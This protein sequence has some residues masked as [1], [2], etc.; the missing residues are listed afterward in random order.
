MTVRGRSRDKRC[1]RTALTFNKA[2][3]QDMLYVI[4]CIY[5][6]VCHL[7]AENKRKI[8]LWYHQLIASCN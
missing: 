6:S 1:I 3:I 7:E 2:C 8:V 5:L 4:S